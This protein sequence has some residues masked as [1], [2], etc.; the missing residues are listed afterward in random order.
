MIKTG[1]ITIFVR[2]FIVFFFA[3]S[4]NGDGAQFH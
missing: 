2:K 1:A 4:V 3:L